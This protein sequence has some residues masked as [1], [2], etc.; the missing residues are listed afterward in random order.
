M[1]INLDK[2]STESKDVKVKGKFIN[3]ELSWIKFNERVL[4][5]AE[6]TDIPLNERLSFLGITNTNLDE[7]ISVR[8][9]GLTDSDPK[10]K[11]LSS[12][13]SFMRYQM[14]TYGVLK[15]ELKKVGVNITKISDLNKKDKDKLSRIF[16]NEIFPA[17]TP[18]ILGNVNELPIFQNGQ[19]SIILIIKNN[20]IESV[21][22]IPIDKSLKRWYKI[23]DKVCFIEDIIMNN[24]ETLFINKEIVD[25]GYFRVIKDNS[26]IL[27]HNQNEFLLD[28]MLKVI[29]KRDMS[30]PIFLEISKNTSKRLVDLLISIFSINKNNIFNDSNI[31]D[32][33][34]LNGLLGSKYSYKSF[35]PFEYMNKSKKSLFTELKEKDILLHHPYESFDTVIKFIQHASIDKNVIAIKQTLYRVSSEDSPIIKALCRAAERGKN[36]TVLIEIKARFDEHQNI[37]LIDKMK[38]AGVHVILGMEYLKTHCKMCLVVRQEKERLKV[39]SHIGTGNYNDKTAKQYTDISYLTSKQKIGVDLLHIFNILSGI[40]TPDEKLQ[41]VFYAPINLKKRLIKNIDREITNIKK[42][43]KSEIFIKVNSINDPE[44]IN[45]LYEASD[46]GVKIYIICRGICS[47]VPNKNI[48]IKSIVGRF[49]EHS[50]IYYFKNDNNPEYYISSADLLTRNLDKRVETLLLINDGKSIKKL[51]NIINIMKKD[52]YNSFEMQE[53]GKYKKVKGKFNSHE[54]FIEKRLSN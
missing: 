50:R 19:N 26:I 40:S 48:Y 47:I 36:V 33:T 6:N 31:I 34:K 44:I 54:Y 41:K 14:K 49:L 22:I 43:K 23:D 39:Y 46:K 35:E 20:D 30:N 4:Y 32:Y 25:K 15:S 37:A 9:S 7:F 27:D 53:D 42:K 12:I 28:R 8:Y 29:E 1:K 13:K 17:L 24:L 52:E 11:I 45:K 2:Y 18:Q 3:R 38:K 10:G 16:N 51:K 5:C 21:I